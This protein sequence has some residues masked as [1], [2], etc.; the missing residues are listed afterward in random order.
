MIG[1]DN[2]QTRFWIAIASVKS[3]TVMP[4]SWVTGVRNSPKVWRIPMLMVSIIEAPAS[5]AMVC[6]LV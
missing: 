4:I 1:W 3:A 5:T 2:P 6:E